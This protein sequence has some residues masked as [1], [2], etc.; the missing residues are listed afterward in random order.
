MYI[1]SGWF[2]IF[3]V[4]TGWFCGESILCMVDAVVIGKCL[5]F[6]F[7]VFNLW[8]FLGAVAVCNY[9]LFLSLPPAMRVY[10]RLHACHGILIRHHWRNYVLCNR[11]N[12]RVFGLWQ[13]I[14]VFGLCT[15]NCYISL[16]VGD[17]R[18]T[19]SCL[20]RVHMGAGRWLTDL[21]VYWRTEAYLGGGNCTAF[22][23]CRGGW[24]DLSV[25]V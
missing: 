8:C 11:Q 1:N 23:E 5:K 10:F 14:K 20:I 19:M 22:D 2:G 4:C 21:F 15:Y 18:H 16:K 9:V 12:G 25:A 13:G 3:N 24:L 6:V 7:F 17:N